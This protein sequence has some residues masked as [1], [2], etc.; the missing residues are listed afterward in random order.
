MLKANQY[1]HKIGEWDNYCRWIKEN[2][3]W[4]SILH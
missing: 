1:I 4:T 3:K 2:S